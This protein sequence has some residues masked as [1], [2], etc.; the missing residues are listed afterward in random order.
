MGMPVHFASKKAEKLKEPGAYN[1][2]LLNDNYTTMDFV[3]DVLVFIFNKNRAEA[4]SI[5]INV[6][7]KGRG[8]AGVYSFDIARTKAAQVHTLAGQYDFPLRCEI[9]PV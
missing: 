3:V 8:V 1:V 4:E 2:V 5:M 7:R 9:E 6:H